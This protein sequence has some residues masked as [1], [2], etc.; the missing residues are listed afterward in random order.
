MWTKTKI[1]NKLAYVGISKLLSVKYQ[2]VAWPQQTK[3]RNVF[4]LPTTRRCLNT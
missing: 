2:Q 1:W 4:P 3:R